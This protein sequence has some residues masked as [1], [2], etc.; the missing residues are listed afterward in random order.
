MASA[1]L[2]S[3]MPSLP[4][5]AAPVTV[6][7]DFCG[8]IFPSEDLLAKHKR[9]FCAGTDFE[10]ALVERKRQQ[11]VDAGLEPDALASFLAGGAAPPALA[12]PGL[13]KL[14]VAEL[15]QRVAKGQAA[16]EQRRAEEQ[17]AAERAAALGY[18]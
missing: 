14:T 1:D 9:R 2:S 4:V 11:D 10:R 13:E 12:A 5:A 18:P 16:R 7:C 8:M 15:R 3:S 17:K 6:A